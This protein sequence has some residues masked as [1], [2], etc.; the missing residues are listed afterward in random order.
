MKV[1]N[2]ITNN[3]TADADFATMQYAAGCCCST[4]T[5][6]CSSTCASVAAV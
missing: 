5:C 4:C 1:T 3:Y 2:Q 6:T